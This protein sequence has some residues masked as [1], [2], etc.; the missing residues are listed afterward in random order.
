VDRA[1]WFDFVEARL[2]ILESQRP[3]LDEAQAIVTKLID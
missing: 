1:G 2:K 3:L